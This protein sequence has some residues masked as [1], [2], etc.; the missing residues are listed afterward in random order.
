MAK[1]KKKEAPK[2]R[3]VPKHLPPPAPKGNKYAAGCETSG[4]PREW[5]EGYIEKKRKAL[6]K[7][8]A[9]PKNYF[10]TSF[11]NQEKLHHEHIERFCNYSPEFRATYKLALSI[12]EQRLVELAIT[13]KH[14]GNFTKFV[15]ANKAGWREKTEL[16]GDADNPLAVILEKVAGSAKDPLDYD[17]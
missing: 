17:G 16:S 12:Q 11:L 9:D 5:D 14:D 7:W 4:R 8:I 6:E 15:L 13:R 1:E 3:P 10:F 2:K